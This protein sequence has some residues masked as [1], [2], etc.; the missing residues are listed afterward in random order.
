[1]RV[2]RL[3]DMSKARAREVM[4]PGVQFLLWGLVGVLG[5][6]LLLGTSWL[7]D[8]AQIRGGIRGVVVSVL[9]MAS[10]FLASTGLRVAYLAWVAKDRD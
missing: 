2:A 1:M 5:V 6:I 8:V 7:S 9:V 3:S 4:E 10:A